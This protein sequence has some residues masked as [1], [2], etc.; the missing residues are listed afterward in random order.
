M[1]LVH[2]I[3][4]TKNRARLLQSPVLR[5][6]V[7]AYLAAILRNLQC[8]PLQVGGTQDHVHPLSGF[9]RNISIA[10]LIK[11]LKTSSTKI[12]RD[13][14][15]RHFGWQAGY[16]VFSVSASTKESVV[17]YI[18]NQEMHHRTMSFQEELRAILS[19]HGVAF[20]ERYLWD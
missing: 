7:H 13:R 19:R 1:V 10:E 5:R 20:D 2:V 15:H 3:S 6:E 8:Q 11:T 18:A 12:L 17:A 9:S 14:G 16:G 4:P